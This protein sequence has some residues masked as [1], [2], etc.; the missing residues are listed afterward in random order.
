MQKI[1][2]T[3]ATGNVAQNVIK[4]LRGQNLDVR[5][6][7]R[8]EGKGEALKAA[9]CEL[10]VGDFTDKA[11]L[12]KALD[13]VD[14]VFLVTPMHEDAATWAG[15]VIEAAQ[16]LSHKPRVVR[17][18]AFASS[19]DGPTDN[20]KLHGHTNHLL[21][22]SGLPY[23]ILQPSFFMQNMFM[24]GQSIAK[25]GSMLWGMGDAKLGLIDVRD[26]ADV[27][28]KV[29]V[30][31]SW[32]FGTYV[33]TGPEALSFHD[34]ATCLTTVLGKEV[35]YVP[36]AVDAVAK[37]AKEM[38]M[39]AWGANVIKDYSTFY[40]ADKASFITSFVEKIAGHKPRSFDVFAKEVL[41]P[42]FQR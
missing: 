26:I 25:D 1:L 17:L 16:H 10:A 31:H 3:G 20:S 38:G 36:V 21:A 37:G 29:L 39:S 42:A 30:D 2:V 41:A 13:G 27:A 40:G 11:S 33:L 32:D 24:S 34:V 18:S 28:V 35:K 22:V 7:V 5:C 8:S 15:N 9:G 19:V 14:T 12:V 23:C 6:L 4:Q